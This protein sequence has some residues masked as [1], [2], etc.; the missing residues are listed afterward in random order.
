MT[1]F[2]LC[3]NIT[4][5]MGT[6]FTFNQSNAR[7]LFD[8]VR[9]GNS[10]NYYGGLAIKGDNNVVDARNMVMEY[11]TAVSYMP[12]TT[13][14]GNNVSAR[15]HGEGTSMRSSLSMSGNDIR[16]TVSEGRFYRDGSSSYG[17]LSMT[18]DNNELTITNTT[19]AVCSFRPFD[20]GLARA[21]RCAIRVLKGGKLTVYLNDGLS[22][23]MIYSFEGSSNLIE[24][25]DG[26]LVP[27][28]L[29]IG[30]TDGT[31]CGAGGNELA[32]RG[33]EAV[34]SFSYGVY[35]G[36]TNRAPVTL[37]FAPGPAG[38]GGNAPVQQTGTGKNVI[39]ATNTVF[40]VDARKLTRTRD[41]GRFAL[42]LMSFRSTTQAEAA[43][44]ADALA[45][46]NKTLVSQPKGGTLSLEADGNYRVLTWNYDK[47]GT[48]LLLR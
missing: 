1:N 34:V 11:P 37:S 36:N 12:V 14:S 26:T 20:S 5:W 16:V 23:S 13:I 4:A 2:Y 31:N 9:I 7:Y 25:A 44:D 21:T 45:T 32:V 10:Y 47:H 42:P 48:M 6:S 19:G 27:S 24:V 30:Y 38:F 8:N 39:V 35:V 41:H 22:V 3:G 43:F 29:R 40:K 33:D 18:G 15:F 46:F 28:T 17:S